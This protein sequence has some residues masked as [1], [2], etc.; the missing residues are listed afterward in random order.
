MIRAVHLDLVWVH[1]SLRV[2]QQL[3]MVILEMNVRLE[4]SLN[5]G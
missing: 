3:A 4:A 2:D 5:D 1:N